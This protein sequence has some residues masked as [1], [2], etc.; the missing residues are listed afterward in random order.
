MGQRQP[1]LRICRTG[2]HSGQPQACRCNPRRCGRFC[3]LVLRAA[4][5]WRVTELLR[6]FSGFIPASGFGR[7]VV[8]PPSAT[9]TAE[10][11]KRA[12]G[13][14]L[15]FRNSVG[16]KAGCSA[17]EA[18]SWFNDR[19][20]DGA[21]I[22]TGPA[23]V[24]YRQKEGDFVARG[25]IADLSLDAYV[26]GQVKRHE[27]T[28]AKTQLKMAEYMRTTRM[29]GNP[30]VTAFPPDPEI[31]NLIAG[32]TEGQPDTA[33]ETLDDIGHEMWLVTGEVAVEPCRKIGSDLYI[34]DGHHR[35]AAAALVAS[36]EGRADA[37]IPV[38]AF[39]ANE[40]RLRSFA[41]CIT[42]PGLDPGAIITQLQADFE[43]E[44]VAPD[45]ALPR[46]RFE[47]GAKIGDG[48]FRLRIPDDRIPDDHYAALNTKLIQ[49]L[50]LGPVFGI[51]KPR[52]DKRLRFVAHLGDLAH[53]S[54][55]ADAWILP[56]PLEVRDVMAVAN[57]D[58]TM[59]AKSTWF[60]P[61]LPSGLVIRPLDEN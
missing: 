20:E 22:S 5:M 7:R 58:R 19:I 46:S 18:T 61:K 56:F 38:G 43:L 24:V 47:F 4:M 55:E 11:K 6:P 8:G 49:D 14:P 27:K 16:R 53:L 12:K 39:S 40:F 29:Y 30:P 31:D 32:L 36:E 10:A 23:V 44:E 37:R 54:T 50:V 3:D 41:R 1:L 13:D 17:D 2:W 33:F 57:S 48:Y 21:L 45:E 25:V 60:A 34:S 42:D 9:L 59:P 15:S 35:L 52:V 51:S 28:I 26:S